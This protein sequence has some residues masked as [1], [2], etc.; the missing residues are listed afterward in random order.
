MFQC[1]S[2]TIKY[3]DCFIM[4]CPGFWPQSSYPVLLGDFEQVTSPLWAFNSSHLNVGAGV[5]GHWF[6]PATCL[7]HFMTSFPDLPLL[8]LHLPPIFP[9][10]SFPLE[11]LEPGRLGMGVE[12]ISS[13]Q[14]W[15][16]LFT[17]GGRWTD[18][19]MCGLTQWEFLLFW[20][21]CICI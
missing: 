8:R 6:L 20:R 15:P 11:L 1:L 7:S 3:R 4:Q 2:R 9:F 12:R 5:P 17:Q 14:G 19:Q 13:E 21:T 16:V 18:T 10:L